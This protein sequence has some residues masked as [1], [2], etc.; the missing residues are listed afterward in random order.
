MLIGRLSRITAPA[1]LGLLI[2]LSASVISSAY[3]ADPWGRPKESFV[4]W[5][6]PHV[7]P[8]HI[9]PNGARLLAVN[10]A[11]NSLMVFD[12][13]SST[14]QQI[15]SIPVGLDPVSV[16]ART[17]DEVWVVNHVSDTVSVVSLSQEKVIAT[18]QTDDEPADVVFAGT[19]QRAFVTASQANQ[20]NVFNPADLNAAPQQVF[21]NGEDPRALA[22]SNDGSEVY[23]A[24]FESGNGTTVVTGG[25]DN[26]F[27]EDL[28]RRPEGPYG[29]INLPP[30]NGTEYNPPINTN[31]PAPPP[32]SMIV[33]KD[34]QG[35][36]MDDNNGDWSR[37][38]SGDLSGLGGTRGGRVEG[39]D[40]PDR[41]IAIVD[42]D[43][44][45]VTYQTRL[46]NANMALSVNP[47]SD[48]VTVV[49]TDAI[50][51]VRW[52]PN[53]NGKFL[54]V[55][56]ARF[57]PG[58]ASTITD[59][60]PHLDYSSASVAQ[61]LRNQSIGDPRGIVWNAAGNRAY[62]TGM[63][64]NN[65]IVINSSGQRVARIEVGEGR[66]V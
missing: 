41:D 20:L 15:A 66:P 1:R 59:L 65:V 62:I 2:S 38:I 40:L 3:A 37:F 34:D 43:S 14:L 29:G 6:N 7:H 63:G 11:N 12:T 21:I 61:S 16:R 8:L 36:W 35:R 17:N 60:N 5:E 9:T 31:I 27:E 24:V 52:E 13:S 4:N 28:V 45:T 22:V 57:Q 25:K 32:V 46:M 64:S 30:N 58:G 39:W 10:T 49:G 33:R 56:L 53:L 50:N 51:E 54:R 23:V 18:L 48:E 19:P 44:L 47:Q 26:N 55:N 42:A